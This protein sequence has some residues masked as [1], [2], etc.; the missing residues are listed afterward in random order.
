MKNLENNSLRYAGG[1]NKAIYKLEK[2]LP[3]MVENMEIQD[4]FLGCGSFQFI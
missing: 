4:C 1:K 3:D 2:H